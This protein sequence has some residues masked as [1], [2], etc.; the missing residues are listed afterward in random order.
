MA[1]GDIGRQNLSQSSNEKVCEQ[2]D[3]EEDVCCGIAAAANNVTTP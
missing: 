3:Q 2:A 1:K